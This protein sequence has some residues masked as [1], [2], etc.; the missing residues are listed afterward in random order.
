MLIAVEHVFPKCVIRPYPYI[1]FK[2]ITFLP[3]CR[4]IKSNRR[5]PD[6]AMNFLHATKLQ[7]ILSEQNISASVQLGIDRYM[8]SVCQSSIARSLKDMNNI[9]KH[10]SIILR[11]IV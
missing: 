3:S 6:L 2:R 7:V 1:L 9:H 11:Y 10:I 4:S 8:I 5:N